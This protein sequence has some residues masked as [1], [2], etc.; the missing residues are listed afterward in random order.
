LHKKIIIIGG[1]ISGLASAYFLAKNSNEVELFESSDQLGG[2]AASFDFGGLF[3]EKFYH[4]ICGGDEKL[5]E[6]AT[7][8]GL[9]DKIR[10]QPTKTASYYHGKIYPFST[11][12]DLLRFTPLPLLSRF[13]VGFHTA[14]AKM[15]KSW[16]QLDAIPAK[17][18][19]MKSL[20]QRAYHAIW[21]PLLKDKFGEN[22]E[23]ISAAW[24]WHRIHRVA[25]SRKSILSKEKMGFFEGGSHTLIDV[26]SKK[27]QE[28]GGTIHLNRKAERIEKRRDGFRI[29]T[30]S[31]MS[32]DCDRI[33]L[34][35]PLPIAAELIKNCDVDFWRKLS[36]IKFFGVICGIFRLKEN[37]SQAFW[38]NINDPRIPSNGLIEY[39]N[40]NP[41][42]SINPDKIVY[43]PFYMSLDDARFSE[44]ES[45]LKK[46]FWD[47]LKII[48]PGIS[49]NI[50]VDYRVF[51]APY[52]QAICP[53]D[54]LGNIP[55]VKAPADDI[56]LLDSTQLYPSDRTLTGLIGLAENMAN[57]YF[58]D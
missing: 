50:L 48:K 54:F 32:H 19:L 46:E 41:L 3:I 55:P 43:M 11:P 12:W 10:W 56:F 17:E 34:A 8:L 30:N 27:I 22:Y 21:H 36:S 18:W 38:L 44:D 2:L 20:G 45:R 49:D 52:A 29:F 5:I 39:S 26:V 58:K 28:M 51:K 1:G 23:Q 25:S 35:V 33:I 42:E 37:I 24:V 57:H 7:E 47:I 16:E 14:Y 9:G 15:K 40:L 6:F 53:V 31:N 4:F 13:R